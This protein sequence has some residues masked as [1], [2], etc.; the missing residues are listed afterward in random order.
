MAVIGEVYQVHI[1]ESLYE[2]MSI[3]KDFNIKI[4]NVMDVAVFD[5]S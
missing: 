2:S 4:D 1:Y 5:R 3:L